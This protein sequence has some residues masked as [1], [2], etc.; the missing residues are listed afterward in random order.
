M[1]Q[2]SI[3]LAPKQLIGLAVRTCFANESSPMVTEQKITPCVMGYFQG[4]WAENIPHRKTPGTTICAYTGYE[5][6]WQGEYTYFIGEEVNS[7][8]NIP[9]GM[10]S[11]EIPAQDYAKF[12]NGPGSMPTTL[13]NTWMSIWLL[14]EEELG[15]GRAYHTDFEVY[16]ERAADPMNTIFDVYVGIKK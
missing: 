3:T 4:N 1:E 13:I 7:L 9:E 10:V 15:G 16:D 6:D 12:T 14:S 11:L 2:I 5:S 8:E